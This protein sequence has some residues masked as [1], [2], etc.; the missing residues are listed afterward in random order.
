MDKNKIRLKS[1]TKKNSLDMIK[2]N[3]GE[4]GKKYVADNSY[5]L[6][7][8]MFDNKLKYVKGIYIGKTPIGLIYYNPLSKNKM[9]I[10]R[11]MI[12]EK[13]QGKGFGKKAFEQSLK[14]YTKK[15]SPKVLLISSANKIALHLYKKFGFVDKQDKES[16]DFYKKYKEKLLVLDL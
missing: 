16:K 10:N 5:T 11:F 3:P 13:Y 4:E 2:L 6:L 15:Y 14:Y 9:Y 1:I 8:A 7:E 12:D